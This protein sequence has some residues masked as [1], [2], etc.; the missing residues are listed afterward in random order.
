[1]LSSSFQV[2][3]ASYL[4]LKN[5]SIT[6]PI[7]FKAKNGN[8]IVK[9][10]ELTLS[11]DNLWL[12]CNYN[13]FDPDVSSSDSSTNLRRVDMNAQPRARTIVFTAKLKL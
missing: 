2:H 4:R 11:G 3:D 12:W 1:M 8:P 9:S 6:Y 5:A 13:G 7:Q 10:L